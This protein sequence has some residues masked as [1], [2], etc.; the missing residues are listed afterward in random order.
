MRKMLST[1]DCTKF[2]GVAKDFADVAI[3]RW[4][5]FL[6]IAKE[7]D[8]SLMFDMGGRPLFSLSVSTPSLPKAGGATPLT[9]SKK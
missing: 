2:K 8:G 1:I 3:E 9:F 7:E 6:R 5:G 4:P